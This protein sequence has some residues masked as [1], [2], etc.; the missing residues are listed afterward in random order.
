MPNGL[1]IR[2]QRKKLRI[3]TLVKIDV[4]DF[5]KNVN[6]STFRTL[7]TNSSLAVQALGV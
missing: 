2:N 7:T 4:G 6:V 3:L 1:Q 5:W